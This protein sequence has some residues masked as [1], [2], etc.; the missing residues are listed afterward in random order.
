MPEITTGHDTPS[1]TASPGNTELHDSTA[2]LYKVARV[3]CSREEDRRM[4]TNHAGHA[5]AQLRPLTNARAGHAQHS[6]L[7]AGPVAGSGLANS[8]DVIPMADSTTTSNEHRYDSREVLAVLAVDGIDM[9]RETLA[10]TSDR[11]GLITRPADERGIPIY[12]HPRTWTARQI[13]Q[14][15]LGTTLRRE[16][17]LPWAVIEAVITG[18]TA[19]IGDHIENVVSAVARSRS[20]ATAPADYDAAIRSTLDTTSEEVTAA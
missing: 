12:R 10:D 15:R 18:D 5:E 1:A 17:K 3:V 2:L 16:H 4:E 7:S 9:H 14:L 13:E 11:I 19:T 8:T 20:L 6:P